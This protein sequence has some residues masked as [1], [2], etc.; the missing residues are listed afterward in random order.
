MLPKGKRFPFIAIEKVLMHIIQSLSC[1]RE[2]SSKII[3]L[4]SNVRL[5][6]TRFLFNSYLMDTANC[7][8]SVIEKINELLLRSYSCIFNKPKVIIELS[9]MSETRMSVLLS[10][11]FIRIYKTIWKDRNKQNILLILSYGWIT[12]KWQA[13]LACLLCKWLFNHEWLRWVIFHFR[14]SKKKK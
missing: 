6:F 9:Y 13:R 14:K 8:K 2:G 11:R 5:F 10:I 7:K 4:P 12:L 1:Y 3:H